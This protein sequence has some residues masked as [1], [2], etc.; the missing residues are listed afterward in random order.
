MQNYFTYLNVNELH[1]N[2]VKDS[3]L[4]IEHVITNAMENYIPKIINV[5]NH[6]IKPK[7]FTEKV[8]KAPNFKDR[9]FVNT[10]SI[11]I[12]PFLSDIFK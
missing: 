3:W 9:H 4:Y 5:R 7:C 2:N 12:M 6:V 8:L 10:N 1:K 11:E